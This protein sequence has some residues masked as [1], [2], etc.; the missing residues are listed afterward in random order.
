MHELV[1]EIV[2]NAAEA[3][4]SGSPTVSDLYR[5]FL[6]CCDNEAE[7]AER[8]LVEYLEG[9]VPE[10]VRK[11]VEQVVNRTAAIQYTQLG[12]SASKAKRR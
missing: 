8:V 5:F 3:K 10:A 1:K 12:L 6:R 2:K 4:P 9:N 7:A 11:C